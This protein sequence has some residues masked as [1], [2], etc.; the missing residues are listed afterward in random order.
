MVDD[1]ARTSR[2]LRRISEQRLRRRRRRRLAWAILGAVTLLAGSVVASV[3]WYSKPEVETPRE[4][5]PEVSGAGES[6]LMLLEDGEKAVGFVLVTSH[7]DL[8]DRLLLF[9]P[10][11]LTVL[12][13]F[14]SWEL[15]QSNEFGEP[16]LPAV[17]LTN[18]L[19]ARVD[20]TVRVPVAAVAGI[21]AGTTVELSSPVLELQGDD[22]VVVAVAGEAIRD[23]DHLE[24]ILGLQGTDDQL[25]WLVRQGRVLEV[26]LDG[27]SST[28][29]LV[30]SLMAESGGDLL[31]GRRVLAAVAGDEETRIT[32]AQARPVA[33]LGESSE[34]YQ[35]PV[36]EAEAF[37]DLH[38][39]Y[40][41]LVD[42]ER[43]RLEVLN[44]T[45]KVAVTPPI[46]AR[47]VRAGFRVVIT[48]NADREDYAV[49]RIVGHTTENQANALAVHEAL[50]FGEVRLEVRQ[51]SGIVDVTVIVG[52][53]FS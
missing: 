6:V 17:T 26:L 50:G 39:P 41:R 28:A 9:P 48:D 18:L 15:G 1:R 4:T 5:I 34:R 7:P 33:S 16:G 23:A 27:I 46:A 42:G 19:G 51:P 35:L 32:A 36:E 45:G 30:D 12:P 52:D 24:M 37:I 21:L 31:L 44:G 43:P 13:G 40:L 8:A 25:T 3:L 29:G 10:S 47:L 20:G 38:A 53:D 2:E 22:Q 14:G 49:T 11:L